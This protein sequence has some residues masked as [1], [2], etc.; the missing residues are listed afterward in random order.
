MF[1]VA[2][3]ATQNKSG[4]NADHFGG[5]KL[6]AKN[7]RPKNAES[8]SVALIVFFVWQLGRLRDAA[9]LSPEGSQIAPA[10]EATSADNEAS[11]S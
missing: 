3:E 5:D 4:F 8:L 11:H 10:I 7:S 9:E 1:A 2:S 6:T